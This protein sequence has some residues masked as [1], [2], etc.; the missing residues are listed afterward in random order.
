V[1]TATKRD[2]GI[3][4]FDVFFWGGGG[5]DFRPFVFTLT[6]KTPPPILRNVGLPSPKDAVMHL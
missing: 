4:G 6:T 1:N 2:S 5:V 3:V